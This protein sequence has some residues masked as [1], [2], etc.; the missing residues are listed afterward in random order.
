MGG[1]FH[2]F[3]NASVSSG[4]A[5]DFKV[6]NYDAKGTKLTFAN[7]HLA[8]RGLT[9]RFGGIMGMDF[10]YFRSAIIDVGGRALYLK[11]Y[12]TGQ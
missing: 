4:T 12:S 2:D 10:L 5:P 7:L 6:G 3:K 8:E 11:P 9:H 1:P